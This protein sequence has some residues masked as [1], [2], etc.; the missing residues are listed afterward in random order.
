MNRTNGLAKVGLGLGVLVVLVIFGVVLLG[1]FQ[2]SHQR[3]ARVASSDAPRSSPGW[4]VRYR[5]TLSLAKRGS[6]H[7]A[8]C[9][10]NLKEMLDADRQEQNFRTKL[11][12]GQEVVN[13]SEAVLAMTKTLRTLTELHR[14]IP[15]LDLRELYPA[16][17]KL[18][19][20]P[21]VALSTEARRAKIELGIQE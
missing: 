7:L 11:N 15:D 20:N 3:P 5:A 10:D 12:N 4:E 19:Q 13:E 17:D 9:T 18:A 8:E 14:R 2:E 16:I 1:R 6:S 21:N